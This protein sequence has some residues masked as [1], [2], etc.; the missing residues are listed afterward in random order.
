MEETMTEN[1]KKANSLRNWI[2]IVIILSI[3][4]YSILTFLILDFIFTVELTPLNMGDGMILWFGI[5]VVILQAVIMIP[6]LIGA[7]IFFKRGARNLS[8]ILS[9]FSLVVSSLPSALLLIFLTSL[10]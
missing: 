5:L 8:I 6:C 3:V 10:F 1:G 2:I 4:V 7:W 9:I